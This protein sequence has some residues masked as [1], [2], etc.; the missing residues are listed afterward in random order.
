MHA[1]GLDTKRLKKQQQKNPHQIP[2]LKSYEQKQGVESKSRVLLMSSAPST[3]KGAGTPPKPALWRAAGTC[4][5]PHPNEKW[6]R[7]A[8][9]KEQRNM[10]FV[11]APSYCS[12]GPN[13]A[14]PEFPIWPPINFYWSRRPRTLVGNRTIFTTADWRTSYIIIQVC[15]PPSG[16]LPFKIGESSR[17]ISQTIASML[18]LS[19]MQ[20]LILV[21]RKCLSWKIFETWHQTLY[22]PILTGL[23][24]SSSGKLFSSWCRSRLHQVIVIPFLSSVDA[25]FYLTW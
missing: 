9:G 13:K 20:I 14:L 19:R 3:T 25:D 21:P 22:L 4:P 15:P 16:S 6:A 7:P 12:R 10:L 2:L 5:Y 1:H 23:L 24:W 17:K 18:P 8:A 11:L